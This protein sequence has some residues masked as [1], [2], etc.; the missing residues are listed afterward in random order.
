MAINY[1]DALVLKEFIELDEKDSPTSW[2]LMKRIFKNGGKREHITVRRSIQKL[3]TLGLLKLNIHTYNLGDKE[4]VEERSWD[5]DSEK[6]FIQKINFDSSY[7]CV[8]AKIENRWVALQ[9]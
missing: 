7:K 2:E 9:L 8:C 1:I 4:K 5:L 6:A 3:E